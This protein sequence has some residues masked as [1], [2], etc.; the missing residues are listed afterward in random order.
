MKNWYITKFSHL[1]NETITCKDIICNGKR[2][3]LTT[4]RG[5]VAVA[6]DRMTLFFANMPAVFH[7]SEVDV[8]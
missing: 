6:Y 1:A 7:A 3:H 4:K 8:K 2:Q 5:L